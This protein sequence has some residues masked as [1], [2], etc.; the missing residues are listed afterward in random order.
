[1]GDYTVYI[2]RNKITK[3]RYVGI[4]KQQPVESRWGANGSNY[5]ESPHLH[6]AISKYG[7]ENFDHE[8]VASGIERD[9]ACL[10]EQHY[11]SHFKTQNH[12]YG[13][14]IYEGGSAPSLPQETREKISCGMRGNKNGLGKACSDEK[15]K[16]ISDAQK[17]RKLTEEHKQKLRK[18]KTVTYPC[19]EEKRQHIIDAK[20]DKKSIICIETNT[21]Y[22]SIHEC[23][24]QMGLLATTICAVLNG[25]CKSTGGYHFRYNDI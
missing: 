21:V 11:I 24:R 6:S 23:A 22:P 3:K 17:G 2:H 12:D 15:K 18:P 16:K 14:N 8:I 5:K 7:W 1:M 13:Y 25:R 19:S 20:R 4:T 10:L 9:D